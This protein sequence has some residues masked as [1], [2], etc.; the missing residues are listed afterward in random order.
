MFVHM[1]MEFKC[2]KCR[3]LCAQIPGHEENYIFRR[4]VQNDEQTI[5]PRT[6]WLVCLFVCLY[7]VRFQLRLS[8][9]TG[10]T[11]S[12]RYTLC[13]KCIQ[14]SSTGSCRGVP[15]SACQLL[16]VRTV[17]DTYGCNT[18]RIWSNYLVPLRSPHWCDTSIFF[19]HHKTREQVVVVSLLNQL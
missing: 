2:Y 18:S 6:P 13:T 7:S 12:A 4:T 10:H 11:N 14:T 8:V 9:L 3:V 5:W 15:C 16:T 19:D 1:L 17:K